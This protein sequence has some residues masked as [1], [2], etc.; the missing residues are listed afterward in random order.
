[1]LTTPKL[2]ANSGAVALTDD[3]NDRM[4]SGTVLG[5]D[6]AEHRRLRAPFTARLSHR[7]LAASVPRI[8]ARAA[9]LADAHVARG[10]FDG[11]ALVTAFG[12]DVV[13]DLMGLPADARRLLTEDPP[14]IFHAFGPAG[15]RQA[16]GPARAGAMYTELAGAVRPDA[17]RPDGAPERLV[18]NVLRGFDRL[19]LGV[20]PA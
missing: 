7:A 4:L 17:V 8:E 14:A 15:P 13:L 9:R 2:F 3:A 18:N 6:G 20:E 5:T 19:P 16:D 11:A 10:A 1:M 12:T